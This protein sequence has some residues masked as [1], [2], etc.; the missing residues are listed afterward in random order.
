MADG[1]SAGVLAQLVEELNAK[2]IRVVDLTTTLAPETPVIDLPPIFA[3]S[4]GLNAYRDLALQF[5]WA[6]L[7]L[8]RP[9]PRRTHGHALRRAD[10][11]DHRQ[12][13]ARECDRYDRAAQIRRPRLRHRRDGGCEDQSRLPAHARAGPVL[14]DDAWTHPAG[15]LGAAA[16]RLERSHQPR[17]LPQRARRRPA[18][19]GVCEGMLRIPGAPTRCPGRRR[20]DHRNGRRPGRHLRSAL[21]ATTVRCMARANS[22]SP[23]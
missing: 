15:A 9:D 4:P 23:A 22:A 8:E 17:R 10:P 21:P 5:P 12:G 7:V 20:R 19:A 2:R 13:S 14:G 3:P 11:L 16:H 1:R 18:L 6:G